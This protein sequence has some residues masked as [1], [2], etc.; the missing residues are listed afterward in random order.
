MVK[1]LQGQR[2]LRMAKASKGEGW[3]VF[4]AAME[5]RW[6][7]EPEQRGGLGMSTFYRHV[8]VVE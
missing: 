7:R 4:G 2:I 6:F 1:D 8:F 3:L 5:E